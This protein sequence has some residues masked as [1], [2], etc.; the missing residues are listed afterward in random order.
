MRASATGRRRILCVFP[1]YSPSFGTFEHAYKLRGRTRAFMPPQGLLAVAAYLPAAWEV[2][3]VDE[4]LRAARE[5]E[6]AWA[7]AVL[8]SG[9]HV[10]RR[11]IIEIGRRARRAGALTVL[12]GPSV[13]ASPEHYP[14]FDYLHIGEIGD[15]TDRLIATIDEDVRRPPHQIRFATDERLPL[16]SFPVPAY[17]LVPI[18]RYFIASVQFSSGCPYRCEFCDIPALYGRNPRLKSPSQVT[19]EL[20]AILGHGNPGAIYFVDDN[21]IGNRRAARELLEEL[22]R[23][24]RARAYPV[25]FACEATL[26][27]AKYPDLL[28]L[29][30]EAFFCTIFCG[31]ETPEEEA[32]HAMAKDHNATMPILEAVGIL[33]SYGIEIVSGIIIGLDTDTP[34]T[35]QRIIDFVEQSNIP[36]LT[37]NLLQA[38][39]R[40]PLWDRLAAEGRL[41]DDAQRDSNVVFRLPYETVREMWRRCV[42]TIYRPEALYRRFAHNVRHT[43]PNRLKPPPAGR[44][45]TANLLKGARILANLMLRVG[46]FGDYRRD[47]WA[48][49]LPLLRGGR[50]EDLIH[51][52]LVAHHLIRFS[53]DASAG[54]EN[55]AFYAPAPR[56]TARANSGQ[57]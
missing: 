24:Q 44:A 55:A 7:D 6:L 46:V 28:A 4:N 25:E 11:Q 17:A 36:M 18:D 32:L 31:I 56:L 57:G 33:N 19:R 5:S 15:A 37:V 39:P 51:V 13:S 26:N 23:W 3:F 38:L 14:E 52:G 45:T 47:Y 35:A 29:M 21:F 50:I 40:T 42:D 1:S 53:R 54:M 9:M 43:Y 10:Q 34:D 27:I 41:C 12:G 22:I 48:M 16:E 49:A 30:R 20:D 2:R 8:V